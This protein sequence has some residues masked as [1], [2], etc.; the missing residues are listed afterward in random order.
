MTK[1]LQERLNVGFGVGQIWAS[2]LT[3]VS[4][5]PPELDVIQT[6]DNCSED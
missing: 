1:Y 2:Y 4:L 3:S 6:L 5:F